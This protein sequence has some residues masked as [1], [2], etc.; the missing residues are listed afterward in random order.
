MGFT[1]PF[2]SYRETVLPETPLEVMGLKS[3]SSIHNHLTGTTCAQLS[4]KT[5]KGQ[6]RREPWHDQSSSPCSGGKSG[7]PEA[8]RRD[9]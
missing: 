5:E 4:V 7:T 9:S 8:V 6:T 1:G 2:P 3:V